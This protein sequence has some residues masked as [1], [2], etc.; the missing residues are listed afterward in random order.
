M[1]KI[2]WCFSDKQDKAMDAFRGEYEKLFSAL[3]KS[4][5]NE[6]RLNTKCQELGSEIASQQSR[7]DAAKDKTH[8]DEVIITIILMNVLML[9]N[10]SIVFYYT[11]TSILF[12]NRILLEASA[13]K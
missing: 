7:V 6:K 2:Y 5:K 3:E 12:A 4:H 10:N 9:F 11:V 1:I 13:R 8:E